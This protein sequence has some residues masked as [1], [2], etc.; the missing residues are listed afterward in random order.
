MQNNKRSCV[1]TLFKLRQAPYDT[2]KL[3]E[4]STQIVYKCSCHI[5][6]SNT[7]YTVQMWVNATALNPGGYII[8]PESVTT[9]F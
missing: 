1:K 2:L 5:V 7:I 3:I 4:E 8:I 6:L 9:A